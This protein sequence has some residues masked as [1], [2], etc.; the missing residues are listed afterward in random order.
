MGAGVSMDAA[1]EVEGGGWVTGSGCVVDGE[2]ACSVGT[3][4]TSGGGGFSGVSTS[5][6]VSAAS[7]AP[8]PSSP[9]PF[10]SSWSGAGDSSLRGVD[11]RDS[12]GLST[13]EGEGCSAGAA[14][15]SSS[16]SRCIISTSASFSSARGGT[17]DSDELRSPVG[18][19]E[20]PSIGLRRG[21]GTGGCGMPLPVESWA[22]SSVET[23]KA[24]SSQETI[25]CSGLCLGLGESGEVWW[26]RRII[27]RRWSSRE[28][29][30]VPAVISPRCGSI[31]RA[32]NVVIYSIP[33]LVKEYQRNSMQS[34]TT[35]VTA[36]A[37]ESQFHHYNNAE[38]NQRAMR[39]KPT[40]KSSRRFR[41]VL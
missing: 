15:S 30:M 11:C 31:S 37:A 25:L 18:D 12:S 35:T 20:L 13:R 1:G 40:R 33:S 19:V 16:S 29:K 38:G 9:S 4:S 28:S 3:W 26:S 23:A 41:A 2:D 5:A 22:M 34:R 17:G 39:K 14:S 24:A 27:A 7:V 6:F 8:A 10:S 21:T 32:P 36:L